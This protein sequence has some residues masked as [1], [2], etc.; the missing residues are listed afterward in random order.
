[1]EKT[2]EAAST[3]SRAESDFVHNFSSLLAPW[4]LAPSAGRVFGYLLLTQQPVSVDDI[5]RG[6][7]ISRVGAWNSA[8][9]LEAFGHIRSSSVS[10][11]KRVLYSPSND[12]SDALQQQAAVIGAVGDLLQNCATTIASDQ[13]VSALERRAHFYISLCDSMN[14]TIA[15]L[16]AAQIDHSD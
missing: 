2:D 7:G 16:N 9:S 12:F 4:G 3:L 8:K 15:A 10:G 13:A 1:M 11:S 5:A 14:S 6:L